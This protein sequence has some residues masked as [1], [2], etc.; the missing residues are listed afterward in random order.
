MTVL[1]VKSENGTQ[2]RRRFKRSTKELCSVKTVKKRLPIISWLPEYNTTKLIQDIIAGITVG[3]T[4]I[5]Q[6][7]A[8]A[9]VAGLSLNMVY[10][11]VWLEVLFTCFWE[12]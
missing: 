3:L 4:A 7:I 2:I 11:P 8:Y 1:K 9:V 10:M 12:L 5:P 6:G